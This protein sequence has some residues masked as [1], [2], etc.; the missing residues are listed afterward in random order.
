M[1]EN[2]SFLGYIGSFHQTVTNVSKC[3]TSES[4][5]YEG[6]SRSLCFVFIHQRDFQMNTYLKKCFMLSIQSYICSNTI[7][8]T[9]ILKN[10]LLLNIEKDRSWNDCMYSYFKHS[11]IKQCLC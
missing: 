2:K 8:A 3:A 6:D 5:Q 9:Y 4:S 7:I 1:S 11:V 10:N